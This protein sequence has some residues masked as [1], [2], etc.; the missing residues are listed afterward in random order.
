MLSETDVAIQTGI[1]P[2][3]SNK[4]DGKCVATDKV[5]AVFVEVL[6]ITFTVD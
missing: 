5:P 4:R 1:F 2:K 6:P 3:G